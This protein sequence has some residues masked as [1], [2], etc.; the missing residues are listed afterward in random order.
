MTATLPIITTLLLLLRHSS[1]HGFQLS[2][3]SSSSRIFS[4]PSSAAAGLKL[5]LQHGDGL[6]SNGKNNDDDDEAF[7][8]SRR[9][10]FDR[11]L[12]SA[13]IASSLALTGNP[14]AASAKV[15]S[16]PISP[17]DE[18][19]SAIPSIPERDALL[20]AIVQTKSS[21]NN[22]N[23]DN[24]AILRA[25]EK[26]IPLSPL[27]GNSEKKKYDAALDGEWKL[28]W[29]SSSNFSPLL[30]L[31]S[32]FRPDS[33]Q[34]F[35]AI[36]AAE[37]GEGRVA[38]GLSGGVLSALGPDAELWLSSGAVGREGDPSTLEIYPPFRFQ[39]GA[40]PDDRGESKQRSKRTVVEA[41]SD[42]EFRKANARSAE[43]QA[44]PKNAYEQLYLEDGGRGSVRVSVIA[45]G[46]PVIVGEM[47]VHQKLR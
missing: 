2:S 3:S 38:Q 41:D 32:P 28:I 13:A 12:S 14:S 31:P 25:I 36:A 8:S 45:S 19:T 46:D 18:S 5:S 24:D 16:L 43:A 21:S 17:F 35:G 26:L 11:A 34:Y 7:V 47:F 40:S 4:S 10:L 20:Q 29:Y 42:A 30:K 39:L 37:V 22:N 9:R 1:C 44:A 27:N 15:V 6:P 23:N 33:Y